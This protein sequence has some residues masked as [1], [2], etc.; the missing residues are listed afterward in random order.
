M[1]KLILGAFFAGMEAYSLGRSSRY[2]QLP[3]ALT[4]MAYFNMPAPH[5]FYAWRR[6]RP[7]LGT[8]PTA[9]SGCLGL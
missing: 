7:S 8:R 1:K 3:T 5:L 2:S 4:L 9:A 6:R